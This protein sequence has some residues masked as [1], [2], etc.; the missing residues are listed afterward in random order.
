MPKIQ[1]E[2]LKI[3]NKYVFLLLLLLLLFLLLLL[4][5]LVLLLLFLLLTIQ[6]NRNFVSK[7]YCNSQWNGI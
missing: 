1:E 5:L 7:I 4:L 6:C 3:I 2:L